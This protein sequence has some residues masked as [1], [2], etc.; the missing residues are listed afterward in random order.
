MNTPL[1]KVYS[2]AKQLHASPEA[3]DAFYTRPG[4]LLNQFG[5]GLNNPEL[6]AGHKHHPGKETPGKP[7]K[8]D[9]SEGEAIAVCAVVTNIGVAGVVI[10]GV[11]L[12]VPP[13]APIDPVPVDA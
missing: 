7:G 4:E 11:A 5:M 13:D 10:C 12:A 8:E 2:L 9:G 3:Q 1:D 6:W